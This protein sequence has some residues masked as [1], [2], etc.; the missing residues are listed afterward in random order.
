MKTYRTNIARLSVLL[1]VTLLTIVLP[2]VR[3]ETLIF[4]TNQPINLSISVPT[5]HILVLYGGRLYP[6]TPEE[7]YWRITQHG[8]LHL[9]RLGHQNGKRFLQGVPGHPNLLAG[10]LTLGLFIPDTSDLESGFISY[11]IFPAA[12]LKTGIV[13]PGQ[14]NAISIPAQS[15]FK[16]A[17][18]FPSD[19]MSPKPIFFLRSTNAVASDIGDT[20]IAGMGYDY[21][22][23]IFAMEFSGPLQFEVAPSFS[24][25]DPIFITYSLSSDRIAVLPTGVIST[26][27]PNSIT[28]E[29]S[30]NLSN[31]NASAVILNKGG[32]GGFFRLKASQ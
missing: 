15:N 17:S 27:G 30:A 3:G 5:N 20:M 21:Y 12:G 25:Q 2:Q 23:R 32:P 10:P 13:A 29:H 11:R 14:T 9:V 18:I 22:L 6:N 28:L 26:A 1:T 8:V 19:D 31:W 16:L 7:V 4:G 24:S